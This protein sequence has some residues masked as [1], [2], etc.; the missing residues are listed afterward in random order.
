MTPVI[1]AITTIVAAEVAR[2][3]R[4]ANVCLESQPPP[5]R[6]VFVFNVVPLLHNCAAMRHEWYRCA[7]ACSWNRSQRLLT[8]MINH[9]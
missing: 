9:D 1:A 2:K 5:A 8:V 3:R 7:A 6:D 4:S